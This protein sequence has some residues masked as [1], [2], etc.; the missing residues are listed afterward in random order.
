VLSVAGRFDIE[1]VPVNCTIPFASVVA[2]IYLPFN[3]M[4]KILFVNEY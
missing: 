1:S 2:I 4:I 3:L